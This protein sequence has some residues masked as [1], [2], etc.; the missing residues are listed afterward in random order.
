MNVNPKNKIRPVKIRVIHPAPKKAGINYA[1]LKPKKQKHPALHLIFFLFIGFVLYIILHLLNWP[2]Q[3]ANSVTWKVFSIDRLLFYLLTLLLPYTLYLLLQKKEM[4]TSAFIFQ[5]LTAALSFLLGFPLAF[6]SSFL[7]YILSLVGKKIGLFDHTFSTSTFAEFF[8]LDNASHMLVFL[9]IV[10]LLPA[11][12]FE[13][14]LR[15]VLLNE[16]IRKMKQGMAVFLSSMLTACF[17]LKS[18]TFLPYFL[19]GL[20]CSFIFLYHASIFNSMLCHFSFALTYHILMHQISWLRIEQLDY[21]GNGLKALYPII[22]KGLLA[23]C[24]CVPLLAIL[25]QTKR[26]NPLMNSRE[27]IAR[28][29]KKKDSGQE[30]DFFVMFLILIVFILLQMI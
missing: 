19:L 16:S 21:S 2:N 12:L 25:S 29:A 9:L 14:I 7:N 27:L 10:C 6:L 30:S 28:H 23:A 1:E 5:P 17:M 20:I 15:N 22:L 8:R 4:N 18:E 26:I 11:L 3:I 24:L 13:I